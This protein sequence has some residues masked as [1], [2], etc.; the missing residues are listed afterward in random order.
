M[1]SGDPSIDHPGEFGLIERLAAI[2]GAPSDERLVVGIGD[3]AAVWRAG[4]SYVMATTDTLV[5]RVHYDPDIATWEDVGW[6]TL[7]VN[8][9][10]IAAMGGTPTLAL[11]TLVTAPDVDMALMERLYVGIRACAEA[12]GVTVAG[13]DVVSGGAPSPT[14][15]VA[16]LGEALRA[17]DGTPLLLRRNAARV[18]DAVAVTGAL[19]GA[20][21]GLRAL[22]NGA[23][24]DAGRS[25]LVQ[26]HVRPMPRLDA[27]HAAI[28]A[29]VECGMDISDGLVQDLGHICRASG[30]SAEVDAGLVP[31]DPSLVSVYPEDARGL[32]LTA[33]EDY[34]LILIAPGDVLATASATLESPLIVIGRIVEGA[35]RVRVLDAG[36][37]IA[38]GQGGWDHLKPG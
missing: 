15:T 16:L 24:H 30:V 19:G 9:S 12:Y 5:P 8:V 13:G 14:I 20:G 25:A 37:E 32:A 17:D 3:D 1:A 11:V 7:A 26:R 21:G 22:R 27:G 10:D 34:E 6:K 23:P 2:I 29:G 33:G 28:A 18:G 38:I 31:L 4:E 35:P 36:R